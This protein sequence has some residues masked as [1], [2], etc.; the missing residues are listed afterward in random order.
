LFL[1]IFFFVGVSRGHRLDR[2]EERP[3]GFE[4]VA[5]EHL[6]RLRRVVKVAAEDI[7]AGK[8]EIIKR[9]DGRE[10][11]DQRRTVV[12]PLAQ[13]NGSHLRHR[14]DRLRKAAAHGLNAGDQRGDH[15]A[16]F[17]CM[18]SDAGRFVRGAG[19]RHA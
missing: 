2:L 7:P 4:L 5:V 10:V 14:S 13:A 12:R 18:G 8:D 15:D 6:C 11:L 9:R 16:K 1:P 19:C 3:H 17:S